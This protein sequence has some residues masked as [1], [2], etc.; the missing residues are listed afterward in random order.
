MA[1]KKDA[2][3]I[4][5]LKC[6]ECK[7]LNYSKKKNKKSNPERIELKKFCKFDRKHTLHKEAK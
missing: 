3:E 4:V 2:T 1:K 7:R 6:G 5:D